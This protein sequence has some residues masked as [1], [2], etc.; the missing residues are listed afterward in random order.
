LNHMNVS[1]DKTNPLFCDQKRI[2]VCLTP[3][4]VQSLFQA[5]GLILGF[6]IDDLVLLITKT[7]LVP[8]HEHE[9][10]CRETT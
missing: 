5:V 8:F 4:F 10:D 9:S 6:L 7:H 2:W 3:A 1:L